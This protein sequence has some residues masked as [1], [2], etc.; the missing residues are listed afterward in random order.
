ADQ[1][2][3]VTGDNKFVIIGGT[4]TTQEVYWKV[5]PSDFGT[6][7]SSLSL[8]KT[9]TA[10]KWQFAISDGSSATGQIDFSSTSLT[11]SGNTI[12]TTADTGTSGH[13]IPYLDQANTFSA[14]QFINLNSSP[15]SAP[16]PI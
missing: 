6:S 13:K 1:T 11:W 14:G 16:S 10:N 5:Q 7:K 15:G 2:I 9:T 8:I 12:L 3:N 4:A